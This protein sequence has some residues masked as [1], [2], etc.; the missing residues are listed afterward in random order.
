MVPETYRFAPRL[1]FSKKWTD[2]KLYSIF[3]ISG[4]ERKYINSMINERID[5]DEIDDD[6][7]EY[8]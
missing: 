3:K 2:E 7:E 1:D 4:P 8:E 6:G 5:P